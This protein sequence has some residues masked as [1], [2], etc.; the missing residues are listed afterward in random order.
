STHNENPAQILF[1]A[2]MAFGG[3][4][5]AVGRLA[6]GRLVAATVRTTPSVWRG[7][8]TRPELLGRSGQ[9]P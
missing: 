4:R 7:P 8:K 3:W 5:L 2:E 6:V 1:Q 9:K